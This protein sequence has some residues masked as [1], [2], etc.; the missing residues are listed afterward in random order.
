MVAS[1]CDGDNRVYLAASGDNIDMSVIETHYS[2]WEAPE[3]SDPMILRFG[4][5]MPKVI[6]RCD[7]G[8]R[9]YVAVGEDQKAKMVVVK[10]NYRCQD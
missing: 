4:E 1:E 10:N 3:S 7:N 5:S 2:C 6:A 8:N 9:V